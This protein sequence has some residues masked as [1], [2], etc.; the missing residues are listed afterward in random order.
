MSLV[1]LHTHTTASDGTDT[2]AQL[3]ALAKEA[4]LA[5]VAVTDHDTV[6]GLDEAEA[7]GRELGVELVRGCEL[8]CTTDMGEMHILGLWLPHDIAPV[9]E[10][11]RWLQ[12]KRT[13]RNVAIVDR[14]Q[15]LGLDISMDEVLRE[16][17]GE[18]VGRPHIAAVL[19]RKGYVRNS[20]EVFQKYLGSGGRAYIPRT[21]LG[22]EEAVHL[23]ASQGAT[24]SLAHPLHWKISPDNLA[25]LVAR[26]K[27]AGLSA[28]EAW[29]SEHSAA[30]VRV[31]LELARRFDLGVSGGSD[32][33][34]SNKPAIALGVGY[35]S[36]RVY[37]S[38]LDDLRA[39][40]RAGFCSL[41]V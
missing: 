11:L 26:L 36:L 34:G 2:P 31:C 1:D 19:L 29:Y 14:L 41:R 24:V 20:R 5:A 9:Q 21:V 39:R 32:Y 38:V 22:A 16:A 17:G 33:H 13:E 25:K 12:Q 37:K 30:D 40:R 10:K 27:D 15:V 35:G 23:L 6:S 18:S 4:G 7:A 28:I 8:S 3:M